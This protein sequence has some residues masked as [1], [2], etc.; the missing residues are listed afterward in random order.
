MSLHTALSDCGWWG[1]A[2]IGEYPPVLGL[3]DSAAAAGAGGPLGVAAVGA[4]GAVAGQ[5]LGAFGAPGDGGDAPTGGEPA[6]LVERHDGAVA[7]RLDLLGA[8]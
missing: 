6:L 3:V 7:E 2:G 1:L 8:A 4:P 5:A